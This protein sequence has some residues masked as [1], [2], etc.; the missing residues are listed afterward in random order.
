MSHNPSV[1][2]A[3]DGTYL[4]YYNG[5][6]Y[7]GPRPT[8]AAPNLPNEFTPSI[9]LATASS[10]AGPWTFHGSIIGDGATNP[11]PVML[12]DG[13]V[14]VY[15]RDANFEMSVY[16]ADHWSATDSYDLHTKN[17][18]R[19]V[20]DHYIWR[21]ASGGFHGVAKN[22]APHVDD[23]EGYG[24]D[25]GGIYVRSADGIEWT[26]QDPPHAYP[27]RVDGDRQLVIEWD[28]GTE[29]VYPNVERPQVYVQDGEP[30]C[31]YVAVLDPGPS[32]SVSD[33]E[34]LDA[35]IDD[36]ERVWNV[37]IPIE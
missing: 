9:G 30:R 24:H 36:P 7:P 22:M 20:E 19:P 31:L 27:H 37:A 6:Q 35:H 25:Y 10:P 1:T 8:P 32:T 29:S 18:L 12:P 23:H 34:S 11:V 21:D 16:A 28:D 2:R 13:G 3:P 33:F 5:T 15:T 26:V 4:L 14:R 17:V